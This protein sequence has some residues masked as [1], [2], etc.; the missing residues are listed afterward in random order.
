MIKSYNASVVKIYNLQ[1][2]SEA[3]GFALELENILATKMAT[4]FDND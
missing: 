3:V 4:I 1:G 2:N